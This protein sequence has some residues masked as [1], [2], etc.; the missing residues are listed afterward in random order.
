MATNRK[1]TLK[2]EDTAINKAAEDDA[3]AATT[4]TRAAAKRSGAGK[5]ARLSTLDP[6]EL[7]ELQSRADGHLVYISH[8]GFYMEWSEFGDVHLIPV[9]EILNMR[10]E[11]PAFFRNHWVYPVSDNADEIISALQLDR[12]YN[13]LSDLKD[14]DE[15]FSY[16]PEQI[17]A[18][19]KDENIVIKENVA[20]RCAQLVR[21]GM[22]D[23]VITIE[24]IE[25]ATGYS[26]RERD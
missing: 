12:Y 6:N 26:I 21:E 25:K 5:R 17:D 16:T 9:S 13:K 20:R 11:Q 1:N 14:Y 7:V 10:N 22:L 15:I 23:S 19:L 3:P 24:A 2:D 18:L 4:K 8:S